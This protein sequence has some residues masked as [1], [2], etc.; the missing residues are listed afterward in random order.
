MHLE[1]RFAR[2]SA[3]AVLCLVAVIVLV[4][5]QTRTG[6]GAAANFRGV[7]RY[8]V[9]VST[10]ADRVNG[11][12]S[13]L[14]ALMGNP[15]RDGISL[16]EALLAADKTRGHATVYVMFSRRMNGKVIEV[17]SELPS[18]HRDHL[19]LEGI[20]PSG[21]DARVTLDARKAKKG[22]LGELLLVQASNVTIRW[23]RF[24]GLDPRRNRNTQIAAVQVGQGR[25][26]NAITPRWIANVQVVDDAFDNSGFDFHY[27][28]DANGSTGM[29]ADALIV[30]TW[31]TAAGAKT[32]ISS[33]TIARNTFR[34]FNNDA[35][36]VLEGSSGATSDGVV[37]VDNTFEANELPIEL[38]IGGK[39]SRV[40]GSQIIG[41]TITPRDPND[42]TGFGGSGISI[43]SNA[44]NGTIDQTL[45]EDNTISGPSGLLLIDASA[46]LPAM[47]SAAGNVISNTQIINNVLHPTATPAGGIAL[48]GG[49]R[50]TS[51]PSC[52]SGVT[53][54]N[55]TIVNNQGN[56]GLLGS[57]PNINGASGNQIT[58]V[59][60][61]NSIFYEPTGTSFIF[62]MPPLGQHPDV[63]MNSLIS[64]SG[65]TGSNGNISSDPLFVNALAADFHLT[66][67]SPAINAGTTVGAPSFDLGGA[68]RGAQPDIGAYEY[69][70]TPWPL[71]SVNA[72]QLGGSGTITSS[73]AGIKCGTACS[74]HFDPG[75]AVTLIARADRGS[76]F[77]GWSNGCTGTGRCTLTLKS[78][79]SVTARFT[80]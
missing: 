23:L 16:R 44:R 66:A 1:Y 45:I 50:T 53:I 24:T 35:C 32:H 6:R 67:A 22:K 27:L 5:A 4:G 14:S 59:T 8:M 39:A 9:V 72:E 43:D 79:Q 18:I 29:L 54:E 49:D 28:G 40:T 80:P 10:T 65:W 25:V 34:H 57:Y 17:R 3:T 68:P 51:P 2:R 19:V 46:T 37:I 26:P 41:N 33:V 21:A 20:A 61:R 31:G 56:D 62:G 11:H 71:L 38:G 12:V 48:I 7:S 42:T 15:G 36:A 60:V 75:S 69:G 74:A 58:N 63:V 77:L 55:D 30:G 52:I 64:G 47:P 76:R 78:A 13:S 73:P 70:A